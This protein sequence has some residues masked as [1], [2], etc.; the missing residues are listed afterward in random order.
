LLQ[1]YKDKKERKEEEAKLAVLASSNDIGQP[2]LDMTFCVNRRKEIS[3]IA[4]KFMLS[5]SYCDLRTEPLLLKKFQRANCSGDY[6]Y[7]CVSADTLGRALHTF[8]EEYVTKSRERKMSVEF[9]LHVDELVEEARK[10]WL[11]M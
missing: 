6:P 11:R 2:V 9:E 5:D 8:Q 4:G 10:A 3:R 1:R 7:Y